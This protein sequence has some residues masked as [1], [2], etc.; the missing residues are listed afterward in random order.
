MQE[1]I[2]CIFLK[3]WS[4]YPKSANFSCFV[5]LEMIILVRAINKC[6]Q[7]YMQTSVKTSVKT[8]YKQANK[9]SLK[10]NVNLTEK[11]SKAT[12]KYIEI[13]NIIIFIIIK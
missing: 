12:L 7:K 8:S 4:F 6:F 1:S 13:I 10:M 9:P 3:I 5:T 2:L 11:L